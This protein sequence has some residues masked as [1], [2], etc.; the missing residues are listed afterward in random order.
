MINLGLIEGYGF[1]WCLVPNAVQCTPAHKPINTTTSA[2]SCQGLVNKDLSQKIS[3]INS[4]KWKPEPG[5]THFL[6]GVLESSC[7]QL[8]L[9]LNIPVRTLQY[10]PHYL[11]ICREHSDHMMMNLG[12]VEANIVE[13]LA[14]R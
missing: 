12:P 6:R 5:S 1:Y 9:H 3:I 13:K 2:L 8:V 7:N 11:K 14:K 10:Y 4:L